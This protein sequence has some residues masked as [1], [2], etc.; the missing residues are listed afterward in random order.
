MTIVIHKWYLPEHTVFLRDTIINQ[1]PAVR[2][3]D[4]A[5]RYPWPRM[6]WLMKTLEFR[7]TLICHLVGWAGTGMLVH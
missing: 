5:E 2:A 1:E 3:M 6:I 7:C 4:S